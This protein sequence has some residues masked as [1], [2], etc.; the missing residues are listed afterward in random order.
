MK[1]ITFFIHNMYMMGG[2]ERVVS[3]I[4]NRL[5][6]E[7][8]V[9]IVSLLKETE[10]TF[11]DIN[12]NIKITNILYKELKPVKL[13][14]PYLIHKVKSFLKDYKTDVF[15]CAGMGDVPLTIFMHNRCKYIAWEHFY[16]NQ[17]KVRWHNVAWK[18]SFS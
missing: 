6:K 1:K 16:S 14:Y 7:F 18:S 13:Y 15:I 9:E 2:T 12:P 10:K 11:Y 5:A 3:L 8:E 4:A 17:G